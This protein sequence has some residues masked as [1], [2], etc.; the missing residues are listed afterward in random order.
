MCAMIYCSFCACDITDSKDELLIMA[1]STITAEVKPYQFEPTT[2]A[3]YSGEES[4]SNESYTD[5]REQARF[6]ERLGKVDLSSCPKCVPMPHGIESQ[7]CTVMNSMH[8]QLV[9]WDKISCITDY[10]QFS[11]V[12]LNKDVIGD[13]KQ[14]KV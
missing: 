13:D 5:V 7:Y 2:V 12:W 8:E 10:D 11:V 6:T 1:E 3:C 4:D 9:E 14:R